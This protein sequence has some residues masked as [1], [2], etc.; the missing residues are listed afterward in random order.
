MS[1]IG[2]A[3]CLWIAIGFDLALMGSFADRGIAPSLTFAFVATIAAFAPLM[4]ALGV[5]FLA[6]LLLDLTQPITLK[7]EAYMSLGMVSRTT[8]A[9]G[10]HALGCMMASWVVFQCR[11]M[12]LRR[13][14]LS[15]VVLSMLGAVIAHTVALAFLLIRGWLDPAVEWSPQFWPRMLSAILTGV[16]G[17]LFGLAWRRLLPILGLPDPFTRQS[18]Y[19]RNPL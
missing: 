11:G 4:P 1:R 10:P 16:P 8:L 12:F 18:Y 6:G 5:A 19:G 9:I 7:A 17:L 13:H 14:P 3:L 2:V 15:L